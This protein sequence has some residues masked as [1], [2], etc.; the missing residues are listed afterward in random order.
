MMSDCASGRRLGWIVGESTPRS[1]QVL[2]ADDKDRL[3]RV[4]TYVLA[5]SPDGC[6]F[7]IL[8][9]ISSGN[10]LLSEDV[11]SPESVDGL[12]Q[13]IRQSPGVSPTYVKGTVRWLSYEGTLTEGEVSLPKVPPR[14]GTEVY[15]APKETL[16]KVFKGESREGGWVR[17]GSLVSDSDI[18][19][20]VS[21]NKL[22]RHLAVL[23]VTGGGKS[24]TVCVLARSLVKELNA[25]VVIFD[26]HG[27]YGDLG[28][29][30]K[31]NYMRS[32]AIQPA[33]LT[34]GELVKLTGMPENAT[35]Q[36][37]VLRQ[38]WEDVMEDYQAGKVSPNEIMGTLRKTVELMGEGKGGDP[39]VGVLNRLSDLE[40]YYG[41]ILDSGVPMRLEEV[42]KPNML[43]VFDLS[44]L[45]ERGADAVVSHYLRRLLLERKRWKRSNGSEGYPT[46]V[47]V[48]I[49]EA[50][51][52]IP[53]RDSTLTKYWAARIA[54]E[55]RKFGIGL[56]IVSQRP[57]NVDPDVL[58]QT[59]NKIILKM[60][61]PQDIKYVQEASE[62]LSE[63]LANMLP[64]LNPGEA[65]VIGSMVKLPAVVKIDL[66]K[67]GDRSCKKGGGDLD[68]VKEWAA[69]KPGGGSGGWLG[70]LT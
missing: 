50:H 34:F 21:V 46:P 17:L 7:G 70:E 45:D 33:M 62:E 38:A 61:E 6:L 2:F 19:Y 14:P 56:V 10:K 53:A 55:G 29:E 65:V 15:E 63:D 20:S 66:C 64:S 13:L 24:N 60:V 5:D 39:A 31:A 32:P 26:M 67:C 58:S 69:R 51:V 9:F 1:S 49:E 25:T 68:L 40:D 28:L 11:T 30:D 48:V 42:I 22:T 36:L 16:E 47:I 18:T 23:A 44:E 57:R 27:E 54:R 37:R 12:V 4:G 41:D 35:N 8:E 43:N 3:P 59:N 52:L